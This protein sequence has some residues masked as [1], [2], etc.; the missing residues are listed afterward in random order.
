MW[1]RREA[2]FRSLFLL[3]LFPL[4]QEA[5]VVPKAGYVVIMRPKRLPLTAASSA[6]S[7]S[8]RLPQLAAALSSILRPPSHSATTTRRKKHKESPFLSYE[9]APS[10]ARSLVWCFRFGGV[11]FDSQWRHAWKDRCQYFWIPLYTWTEVLLFHTV[12]SRI[13]KLFVN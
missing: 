3:F 5:S 6:P 4:L 8:L 7:P 13:G 2:P 1:K 10:P 11:H 12:K 9:S